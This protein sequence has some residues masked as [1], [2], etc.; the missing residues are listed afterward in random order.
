MTKDRTMIAVPAVHSK[1]SEKSVWARAV[2]EGFLEEE[3]LSWHM[4]DEKDVSGEGKEAI[5]GRAHIPAPQ[6]LH[7]PAVSQHSSSHSPH[8]KG[9]R[10]PCALGHPGL[11]HNTQVL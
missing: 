11:H 6:S 5:P 1:N 2:Q 7:A 9:P 4:K 3:A 10:E 8:Q